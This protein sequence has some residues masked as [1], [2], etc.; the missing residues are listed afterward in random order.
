MSRRVLKYTHAVADRFTLDIPHC[1]K[2]IHVDR[3]TRHPDDLAFWFEVDDREFP[4]TPRPYFVVGTGAFLPNEATNHL[5]SIK[6]GYFIWHVYE[7]A[8]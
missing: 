3:D 8:V 7:G 4:T 1:S 2:L 5:A 6:M